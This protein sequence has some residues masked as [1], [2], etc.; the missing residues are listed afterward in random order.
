[1]PGRDVTIFIFELAHTIWCR[2]FRPYRYDLTILFC[3]CCAPFN[4]GAIY[5]T[6]AAVGHHIKY[7]FWMYISLDIIALFAR[8]TT[9]FSCIA[10]KTTPCVHRDLRINPGCVN[11]V[12]DIALL[13]SL[14]NAQT[15]VL[16][17]WPQTHTH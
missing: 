2:P 17:I 3:R 6:I 14:L 13:N 5:Y 8:R 9:T 11:T 1:M 15:T 10:A 7:I 4:G 16:D 12:L